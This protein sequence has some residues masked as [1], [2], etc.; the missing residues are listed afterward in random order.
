MN[1]EQILGNSSFQN[2]CVLKIENIIQLFMDSCV[3]NLKLK[4]VR[5]K[6]MITSNSNSGSIS[7]LIGQVKLQLNGIKMYI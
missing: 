4:P 5:V 3:T 6:V 7:I 1:K 2:D